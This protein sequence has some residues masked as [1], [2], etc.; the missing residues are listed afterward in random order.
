M[1]A[2][3]ISGQL[4]QNPKLSIFHRNSAANCEPVVL[5]ENLLNMTSVFPGYF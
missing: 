4:I 5:G 3:I 1:R 2:R